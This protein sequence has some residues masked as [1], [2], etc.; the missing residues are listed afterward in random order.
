[1]TAQA[2][3]CSAGVRRSF[4][5][6][7]HR[8]CSHYFAHG[9]FLPDGVLIREAGTLGGIPGFLIHGCNDLGGPVITAGE[10]AQA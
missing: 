10:L 9:G 7:R 2:R 5:P 6:E 8:I 1:M 4:S 3:G